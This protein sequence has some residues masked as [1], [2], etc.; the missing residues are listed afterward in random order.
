MSWFKNTAGDNTTMSNSS[1]DLK[2][3]LPPPPPRN[4]FRS[5]LDR[6]ALETKA[7]LEGRGPME[8]RSPV[9]AK[10]TVEAKSA[11]DAKAAVDAKSSAE[12]KATTVEAKPIVSVFGASLRFKGEL[13]ADEDFT[14]QGRIEGSIHHTQ[15][16]TI[17][18]D[19]VVK[20]DSRARN[21]IVDGTIEGDL[22]ALES[23]AI[24][25]TAKVQG[26]LMAPRVSIADGASFNGKVDMATA[27]RAAR[28]I[29][30]RQATA[31][32]EA[33]AVLDDRSAEQVLLA[34]AGGQ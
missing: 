13:R 2:S 7:A 25:P 23:I 4:E 17:G 19:G 29:A 28:S 1:F 24:R 34:G 12:V 30:D 26:N 15:N 9:E 32:A 10:S 20:G 14:L 31:P 33:A 6:A 16:L 8:M 18:T 21:I 27:A 11:V 3:P 22:Y 5:S